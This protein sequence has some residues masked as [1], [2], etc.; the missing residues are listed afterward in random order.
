MHSSR[1][2]LAALAVFMSQ[3][4][5]T[6]LSAVISKVASDGGIAR[7]RGF[8]SLRDVSDANATLIET[9][10]LSTA[11]PT[12]LTTLSD[13]A[14]LTTV[15]PVTLTFAT[16]V[17][18]LSSNTSYL[19]SQTAVATLKPASFPIIPIA[20][21][22]GGLV[23][24]I[25][26]VILYMLSRRRRQ[27][28]AI[29]HSTIKQLVRPDLDSEFPQPDRSNMASRTFSRL[30]FSAPTVLCLFL[31]LTFAQRSVSLSW[32]AVDPSDTEVLS[33]ISPSAISSVNVAPNAQS[34]STAPGLLPDSAPIL[35]PSTTLGSGG[36]PVSSVTVTLTSESTAIVSVPS[37]PVSSAFPASSTSEGTAVTSA[38]AISTTGPG[39]TEG[40]TP[41]T[42]TSTTTSSFPGPVPTST[43]A[44]AVHVS[45]PQ[46]SASLSSSTTTFT[47]VS[48]SFFTSNGQIHTTAIP[49]KSTSVTAV[50]IPVPVPTHSPTVN[51]AKSKLHLSTSVAVGIAIGA[52]AI[53]L[54][55]VLCYIINR[56]RHLR[57]RAFLRLGEEI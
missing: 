31:F 14:V 56:R 36:T 49:I 34:F 10:S 37:T 57:K 19:P 20:A 23:A 45:N 51:A 27:R 2:S 43:F 4:R 21:G 15:V 26:V 16:L 22:G 42:V 39:V 48:L 50:P 54:V 52:V 53:F 40:S 28:K 13:G 24:I 35:Y 9:V 47:A 38:S 41:E 18:Y 6:V 5:G 3:F 44:N 46:A 8:K 33:E 29:R 55:L 11:S 12:S 30:T 17:P 25:L 32:S 1:W 7:T